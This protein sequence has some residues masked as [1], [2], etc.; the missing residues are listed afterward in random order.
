MS[1]LTADI[2]KTFKNGNGL[3]KL[4][5]INVGIFLVF[6]ILFVLSFLF[7]IVELR[8]S[9]FLALPADLS[10]LIRKPWTLVSYMFLH[11]SF[12]H[13]LFNMLW[14]YFGGQ[15]FLSFF[16]DKQII[17]TYILGGI[18]GAILFIISFNLFPVFSSTLP[19]SIA[20]GASASVLAIIMAIATKSPNYSI[21]LFLIGNIKLKHIALA[22]ILLDILS[23]PNGNAGGHIAHLGGAFFGFLYVKQLN[24]GNDIA[25]RFNKIIDYLTD[26]FRSKPKLKKVYSRRKSDQD[27]RKQK[28]QEQAKIDKILEKIAK[29]GYEGLTKEE[30]NILFK[31]SKK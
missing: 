21:R 3:T 19:S 20:M 27:F 30:K 9:S 1:S 16:D 7:N 5:Y 13:L 22:S 18:S 23:I 11:Q 8:F 15:I 14:L 28:V 12:F 10:T 4:I 6:Q 17:S 24:G 2:K 31:A 25:S 29:S 26:F